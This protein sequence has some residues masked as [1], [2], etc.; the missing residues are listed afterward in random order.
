[1]RVLALG[2]ALVLGPFQA[3]GFVYTWEGN[4]SKEPCS[5]DLREIERVGR[6]DTIK[7]FNLI[8]VHS[9]FNFGS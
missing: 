7:I 1:M 5:E 6:K 8:L 9:Y 4:R 3:R 2:L